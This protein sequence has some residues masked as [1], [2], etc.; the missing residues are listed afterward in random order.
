MW[1]CLSL[2]GACWAYQNTADRRIRIHWQGHV[3]EHILECHVPLLKPPPD[4]FIATQT[5]DTGKRVAW[6]ICQLYV[7]VNEMA[8]A[9]RA[10]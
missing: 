7:H 9:Y 2:R 5:T 10:K 1:S 4:D 8:M 3:P 6:N